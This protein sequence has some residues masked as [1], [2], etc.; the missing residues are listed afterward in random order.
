VTFNLE[1]ASLPDGFRERVALKRRHDLW[2]RAR[3]SSQ[4]QR[5]SASSAATDRD[6]E[7]TDDASAPGLVDADGERVAPVSHP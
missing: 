5:R 6:H 1:P 4:N 7:R 3:C 2:S